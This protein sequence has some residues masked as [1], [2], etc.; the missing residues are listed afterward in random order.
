V[1]G[2]VIDKAVSSVYEGVDEEGQARAY[3]RR[4]RVQKPK[5]QKETARI[6]RSLMRAGFGSKTI[7]TILKK[8]DVDEETIVALEGEAV[9]SSA[10]EHDADS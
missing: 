5:N 4:K 7:F 2:D 3:L 9:D 6:F 10:E 1:H 8:W